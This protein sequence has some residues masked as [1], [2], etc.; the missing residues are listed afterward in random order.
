M[1]LLLATGCQRGWESRHRSWR[2]VQLGTSDPASLR[3]RFL[4]RET[5]SSF[6]W[7]SRAQRVRGCGAAPCAVPAGAVPRQLLSAC[8]GLLCPC[9]SGVSWGLQQQKPR[10]LLLAQR[11]DAEGE[12]GDARAVVLSLCG[13]DGPGEVCGAVPRVTGQPESGCLACY[14]GRVPPGPSPWQRRADGGRPRARCL[15]MGRSDRGGNGEGCWWPGRDRAEEEVWGTEVGPALADGPGGSAAPQALLSCG[16]AGGRQPR[17][18]P[19]APRSRGRELPPPV[20]ALPVQ[21][22]QR[23]RGLTARGRR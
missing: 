21:L 6:L 23:G 2:L 12:G 3:S 17:C 8:W 16:R 18:R 1:A 7:G 5:G 13:S 10:L 14:P 15:A 20:P 9:C 4:A 19:A 11:G 22:R